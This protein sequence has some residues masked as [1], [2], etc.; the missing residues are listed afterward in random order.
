MRNLI[1][2]FCLIL[3]SCKSVKKNFIKTDSTAVTTT[4][5]TEKIIKPIEVKPMDFSGYFKK[6][7]I[8]LIETEDYSLIINDKDKSVKVTGKRK[9]I[10]VPIEKVTE[11][12]QKVNVQT[13]S[14]QVEKMPMFNWSKII[15][16]IVVIIGLICLFI[17][18]KNKLK[19]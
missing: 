14:K 8:S 16:V 5:I 7:T 17:Y 12:N 18:L 1:L 13:K 15:I 2:F 11:I 4:R 6:D 3:F 10:D 19:K 9:I